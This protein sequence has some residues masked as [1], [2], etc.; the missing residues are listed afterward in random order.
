M[1]EPGEPGEGEVLVRPT[2]SA[3]AARTSTSSRDAL[4]A[5]GRLRLPAHPGPRGRGDVE[6]VGPGCRDE[7]DVGRTVALF[8]LTACGHCYPCRIGRPNVCVNFRLIGI[9][10]DGGLQELLRIAEAQVFAITGTSPRSRRSSSRSRS[11]CAPCPRPHRRRRARRRAR[12]R[13][14]RAVA[15]RRRAGPRREVLLVDPLEDRLETARA[16]GADDGAVDDRGRRR[17]AR[18]R[19]DRRRR[20]AGRHRRDR[21]AGGRRGGGRDGRARRARRA[22]RDVRRLGHAAGRRASPRR[23]ST[24]SASRAAATASSPRPS[25]SSSATPRGSLRSISHEFPL[26]EAPEAMH[27]AMEH[28]AEV[29]KVMIRGG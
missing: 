15:S 26:H 1:A 23:S 6:A 5:R 4:G 20:P 22:G 29:M 13:A 3:S 28:P 19:L 27:F 11:R 21:R 16:L 2:P 9:H 10:D 24:C 7:I 12:G 14:D 17:R 25:S 18:A 8:P